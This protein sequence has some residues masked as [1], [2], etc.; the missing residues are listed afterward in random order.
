M[1]GKENGAGLCTI[2]HWIVGS[3]KHF[4]TRIGEERNQ[5]LQNEGSA[6]FKFPPVPGP[7]VFFVLWHW[8][9]DLPPGSIGIY[10]VRRRHT[11]ELWINL[12]KNLIIREKET[13]TWIVNKFINK[14]TTVSSL[15]GKEVVGGSNCLYFYLHL[16]E[17]I[18]TYI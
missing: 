9:T 14:F 4:C 8:G 10:Y 2:M 1:C 18:Y 11:R 3:W 13:H 6:P 12:I 7:L 5:R 15:G 16:F 17:Y